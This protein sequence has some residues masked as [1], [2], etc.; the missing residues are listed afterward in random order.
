M[1]IMGERISGD[2]VPGFSDIF[3]RNADPP[4]LIGADGRQSIIHETLTQL[5]EDDEEGSDCDS[6]SERQNGI[7]GSEIVGYVLVLFLLSSP[8]M[9]FSATYSIKTLTLQS[10]PELSE[11]ARSAEV[12]TFFSLSSQ[13]VNDPTRSL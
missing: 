4:Q 12:C 5:P 8:P 2:L 13:V 1:T 11:L 9:K 3:C 7:G 10:D 6:I